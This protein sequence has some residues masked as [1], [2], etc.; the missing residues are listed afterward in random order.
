MSCAAFMDPPDSV[1]LFVMS[2]LQ[3][4]EAAQVSHQGTGI[5]FQIARLLF[6]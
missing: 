3:A 6:D 5:H 4:T 2:V 1:M